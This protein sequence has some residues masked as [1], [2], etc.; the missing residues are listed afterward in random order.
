[1][2]KICYYST[3]TKTLSSAGQFYVV[4]GLDITQKGYKPIGFINIKCVDSYLETRYINRTS[5]NIDLLFMFFIYEK[6]VVNNV[7]ASISILYCK[8]F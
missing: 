7:G 8:E 1:M 3:P 4:D 5:Q 6:N 2:F